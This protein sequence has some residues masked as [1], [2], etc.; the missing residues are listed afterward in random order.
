MR[1]VLL[2]LKGMLHVPTIQASSYRAWKIQAG[3]LIYWANDIWL[4]PRT[5]WLIEIFL[6]VERFIEELSVGS[7]ILC[8]GCCACWGEVAD[9]L[10]NIFFGFLF[11]EFLQVNDG[12]S[13][14][15]DDLAK[16]GGISH[17]FKSQI[18]TEE[19][20]PMSTEPL[21]VD[22]FGTPDSSPFD[23]L[24]SPDDVMQA[25]DDIIVDS[26][27]ASDEEVVSPDCASSSKDK[28]EEDLSRSSEAAP[29]FDAAPLDIP[30]LGKKDPCLKSFISCILWSDTKSHNSIPWLPGQYYTEV[31]CTTFSFLAEHN[32][33]LYHRRRG[34]AQQW[35][36]QGRYELIH[37]F[38]DHISQLPIF[39]KHTLWE[40]RNIWR[41][42]PKCNPAFGFSWRTWRTCTSFI[43][44]HYLICSLSFHIS[45]RSTNCC[46]DR[47]KKRL[48]GE[49]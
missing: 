2:Y 8:I 40:M 39:P 23:L 28:L 43:V 13:N 18:S 34:P 21:D 1:T 6:T 19:C 20:R 38:L 15:T 11:P 42:L 29:V 4:F 31:L 30:Y 46:F 33:P 36:G 24:A 22:A 45:L 14:D 26:Q 35:N 9:N 27:R 47:K 5:Y 32:N 16:Q 37:V 25:L 49:T 10:T 12:P 17:D 44:C 3:I 48:K 7:M 41:N